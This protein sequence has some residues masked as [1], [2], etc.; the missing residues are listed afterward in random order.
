MQGEQEPVARHIVEEIPKVV[1]LLLLVRTELWPVQRVFTSGL[2][3]SRNFR[4]SLL[5][6]SVEYPI[7][8]KK[9]RW[10][11]TNAVPS[12]QFSVFLKIW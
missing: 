12:I 9:T 7:M 4:F 3:S 6:G 1:V 11:R 8:K 5:L 10:R 2:L